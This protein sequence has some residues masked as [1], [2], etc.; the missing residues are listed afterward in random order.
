MSCFV[1]SLLTFKKT[2]SLSLA[3]VVLSV[4]SPA[5]AL[6]DAQSQS[7]TNAPSDGVPWESVGSVNGAG[8]NYLGAGWV[9][10]PAHVGAGTAKFL[11]QSFPWDGTIYWLT[12]SDGTYADAIMFHLTG[13]P[14]LPRMPMVTSTP[15]TLS[16]VDMIGFGYISGSAQTDFSPGVTGFYL[17]ATQMKGWG[18]NRI[19]GSP[20]SVFD[21]TTNVVAFPTTFDAAPL[22]TSDECQASAGD[23]GGA[24][25]YRNGST[26]QL[27]GMVV[28]INEPLTSRPGNTAVYT[29]ET[30]SV[31]IA[32]Y[33]N[34]I[35][36]IIQ[37]TVPTLAVVRGGNNLQ[38]S[39][40]DTGVAYSLQATTSLSPAN[41]AVITPSE[42]VTNGQVVATVPMTTSTRCFRLHR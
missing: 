20:V 41:W 9:L 4:I 17:S 21:G 13:M 2:V 27:A 8:G 36:A 6:V 24:V 42:T 28:A 11:G 31:D 19:S 12:N 14:A 37:G 10:S 40:P 15:S 23:S 1:S 32:T 25:F 18:N 7:N 34:Q 22:Q 35:Q 5:Y 29:D 38:I 39:W 26:W 30:Y 33:R 3:T 16:S